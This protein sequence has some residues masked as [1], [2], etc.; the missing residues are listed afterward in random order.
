IHVIAHVMEMQGRAQEGLAFLAETESAWIKGTDFSTHL[1]WHRALFHLDMDN[2]KAAL[3]VYDSQIW[4]ED[5]G[6]SALAD[7]SSLLWRLRIH[8]M[9]VGGRWNALADRWESQSLAGVRLF[10]VSHAMM[11]FAAVGRKVAAA[12][13]FDM[14]REAGTINTSLRPEEALALPLGEAL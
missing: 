5:A 8:G 2:P 3:K 9:E 13:V 11:A 4:S 6:I 1:A 10:Y 14:L 7:A 12:R